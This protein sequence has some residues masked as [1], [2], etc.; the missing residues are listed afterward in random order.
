MRDD[1][2]V[3]EKDS[4]LSRRNF[5]K[6]SGISLSV[7]LVIGA[8]VVKVAGAEVKVYG[9]NK[10][11]VELVINGKKFSAEIEPRVTLLDCIRNEFDL[12]GAKRVCD[13]ATC[14]ACTVIMDGKPVYA[15]SVLA[16][17][18]QGKKIT[19]VEGL[20]QGERL[21]PIQQAFVD[22]DGQQC[23]FCTP[24]FVV[25]CK[26]FLDKN[27]HPTREQ[28]ERG[29]GGNLCRCGTYAGVREAVLQAAGGRRRAD[30]D[31]LIIEQEGG[32]SNG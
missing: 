17:E 2:K 24:G 10:T 22:N 19:T 8:R 5:L 13:R 15:C 18:A 12:T 21:H 4:G 23:G 6:V 14:G 20:M 11:P 3:D 16:I 30:A 32:R 1:E 31:N 25:A 7:P 29:L 27:P 26:A 9:P 28:V